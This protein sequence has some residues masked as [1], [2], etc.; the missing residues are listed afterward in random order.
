MMTEVFF[1]GGIRRGTDVLKA[2][3]FG[4]NAVFLDPETPLWALY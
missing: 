4:A 1:S 3:G 2:L